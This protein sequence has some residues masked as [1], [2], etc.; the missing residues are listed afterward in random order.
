[1]KGAALLKALTASAW[2]LHRP[3]LDRLIPIVGKQAELEVDFAPAADAGTYRYANGGPGKTWAATSADERRRAS[4]PELVGQVAIVP[5]AGVIA[6]HAPMVSEVSTG[7]GTSSE[8]IAAGVRAA[9]QTSA[10]TIALR[11]DSPGGAVNG[12]QAAVDAIS[13]AK[14]AG[15]RIVAHAD[16][17]AASLAYWIAAGADELVASPTAEVG[18]IGAYSVLADTSEAAVARGIQV[19]V[20]RAGDLK[21]AGVPGAP[22]SG[23]QLEVVQRN[24]DAYAGLFHQAVRAGRGF[25]P[26]GLEQVSTGATWVGAEAVAVG[27]VDR[28]QTFDASDVLDPWKTFAPDAPAYV[29]DL[30]A[31]D[32]TMGQNIR[33][34]AS[35]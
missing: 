10:H 28:V 1:M 15:K 22:I 23:E 4:A 29:N 19:H 30:T 27:L 20:V 25:S 9:V 18:A 8:E 34:A 24:V 7:S 16:D 3:V 5:I 33:L 12:V 14:A 6:Q 11:F 26:A 2:C 35:V 17:Y 32:E 31:V 21:G 13:E